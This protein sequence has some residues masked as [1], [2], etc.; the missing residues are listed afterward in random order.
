MI[1]SE[2]GQIHTSGHCKIQTH[3]SN[4]NLRQVGSH[5]LIFISQSNQL[6]QPLQRRLNRQPLTC[7]HFAPFLSLLEIKLK[8]GNPD[9][10]ASSSTSSVPSCILLRASLFFWKSLENSMQG[11]KGNFLV[12]NVFKYFFTVVIWRVLWKSLYSILLFLWI[13]T[14]CV[15][16]VHSHILLYYISCIGKKNLHYLLNS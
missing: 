6:V 12:Y 1:Q 13:E 16:W 3:D 9:D 11:K 14:V 2:N 5:L 4:S 10:P 8:L 15:F 7:Q